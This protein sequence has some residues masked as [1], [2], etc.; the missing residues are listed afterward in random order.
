[1]QHQLKSTL[2]LLAALAAYALPAAPAHATLLSAGETGR[3]TN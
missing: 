1:M 2:A 3:I